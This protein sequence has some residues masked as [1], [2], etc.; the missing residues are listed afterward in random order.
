MLFSA[1]ENATAAEWHRELTQRT[2]PLG[3]QRM[4]CDA[5]AAPGRTPCCALALLC[6]ALRAVPRF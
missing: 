3:E 2:V 4:T 1:I 5:L 6:P